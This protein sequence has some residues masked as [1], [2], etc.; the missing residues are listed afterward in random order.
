MSEAAYWTDEILGMRLDFASQINTAQK[1]CVS[2]ILFF[3]DID[4]WHAY[5]DA[6]GIAPDGSDVPEIS[7]SPQEP[8]TERPTIEIPTRGPGL[9]YIPPEQETQQPDGCK[10]LIAGPALLLLSVCLLSCCKFK[11][12]KGDRS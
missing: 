5:A 10:G 3:A 8:E 4:A 2:D 1:V 12:K 6:H 11:Y 7:T 9:E